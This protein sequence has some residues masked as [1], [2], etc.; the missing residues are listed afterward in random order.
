MPNFGIMDKSAV[1]LATA[2]ALAL[3]LT[4]NTNGEDSSYWE[5]A[6]NINALKNQ[7]R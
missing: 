2:A 4:A 1:V 3:R 6:N 7:G 5:I